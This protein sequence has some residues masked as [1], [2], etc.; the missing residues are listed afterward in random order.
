MASSV[1]TPSMPRVVIPGRLASLSSPNDHAPCVP[2]GDPARSH[3]TVT[4]Q[5]SFA[6]SG[7]GTGRK[8]RPWPTKP[9]P[10]SRRRSIRGPVRVLPS[11]CRA[12]AK[13]R[14][15]TGSLLSPPEGWREG[16]H[17]RTKSL[18]PS[19]GFESK[20]VSGI[21]PRPSEAAIESPSYRAVGVGPTLRG[22]KRRGAPAEKREAG[23]RSV[24]LMPSGMRGSPVS[25]ELS[26][27]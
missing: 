19:S 22:R 3:S 25:L 5:S 2:T 16:Y 4:D 10:I 14:I 9:P 27:R 20:Y 15:I 8:P 24:T 1:P 13:K 6:S 11:T 23:M 26:E 7:G 12:G 18:P 21:A 17:V